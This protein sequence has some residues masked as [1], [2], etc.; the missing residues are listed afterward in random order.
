MPWKETSLPKKREEFVLLASKEGSN[1][2]A[3]C[4]RFGISRET[5]YKWLRSCLKKW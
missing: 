2:S 5:G 4:Q 1:M 3:L